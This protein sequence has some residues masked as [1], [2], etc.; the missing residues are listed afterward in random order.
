MQNFNFLG[1]L[2]VSVNFF[3]CYTYERLGGP[4]FRPW[5]EI[6]GFRNFSVG[7]VAKPIT[8]QNFNLLDHL[9]VPEHFGGTNK[10]TNTHSLF[11]EKVPIFFF[12]NSWINFFKQMAA[13]CW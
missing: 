13:Y 1:H 5:T 2:E 11:N 9:E 8:M 3:P 10:Q 6:S 4:W 12:V 7:F